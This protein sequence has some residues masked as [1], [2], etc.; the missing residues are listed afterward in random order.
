VLPDIVEEQMDATNID[1][2]NFLASVN[3]GVVGELDGFTM[4]LADK[5][6]TA[7]QESV[8]VLADFNSPCVPSLSPSCS[9]TSLDALFDLNEASHD[10]GVI[11]ASVCPFPCPL[12]SLAPIINVTKPCDLAAVEAD[13]DAKT[14]PTPTNSPNIAPHDHEHEHEHK[15]E[16]QEQ[17]FLEHTAE[18]QHTTTS[19]ASD[20]NSDDDISL[21]ALFDDIHH[22]EEHATETVNAHSTSTSTSK[23]M[24]TFSREDLQ[25][26][27]DA[28]MACADSVPSDVF[29][30][31]LAF[32]C[33]ELDTMS[34][35]SNT[36]SKSRCSSLSSE[37]LD[38]GNE[39]C[40]FVGKAH[41]SPI[42]QLAIVDSSLTFVSHCIL[43]EQDLD[44]S[45]P[46]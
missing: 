40:S 11:P 6:K 29:G 7:E 17:H 20:E 16:K 21:C 39:C 37:A 8:F 1:P 5:K 44:L 26:F 38:W 13:A 2:M 24:P 34:P 30:S 25:K 27:H 14:T 45:C 33:A 41:L 9:V 12:T 3:K 35:R 18:V 19:H 15:H 28:L 43:A 46:S 42:E 4:S 23:V 32:V 10:D 36:S 22:E 31:S